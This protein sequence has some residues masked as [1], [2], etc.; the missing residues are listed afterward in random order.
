MVGGPWK[1]NSGN[2]LSLSEACP[3]V[4]LAFFGVVDNHMVNKIS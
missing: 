1:S 3:G 4:F 2:F